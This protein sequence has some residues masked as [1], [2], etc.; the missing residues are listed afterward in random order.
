MNM[1]ILCGMDCRGEE[2]KD[3]GLG[4]LA[5]SARAAVWSLEPG[6]GWQQWGEK[7]R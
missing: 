5:G 3:S 7:K 4:G 2:V 6:L 1:A